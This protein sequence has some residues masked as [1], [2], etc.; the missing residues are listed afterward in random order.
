MKKWYGI[1]DEIEMIYNG[2]YSDPELKYKGKKFC[3]WDI[4]DMFFDM[5]CEE[6]NIV[7]DKDSDETTERFTKWLKE[8]KGDVYAHMD[9]LVAIS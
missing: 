7:E 3:Y 1:F 5:F 9:E 2:E 8:N 6:E 4:E